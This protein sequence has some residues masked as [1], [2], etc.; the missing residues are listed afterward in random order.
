V[1]FAQIDPRTMDHREAF[2]LA[3]VDGV[4]SL[5]TILDVSGMSVRDA[6]RIVRVLMRRGIIVLR[7]A[8]DT[9]ARK[10]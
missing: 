2:V 9:K 7:G 8:R 6:L 4:T 1:A 3:Q 5:E 10:P